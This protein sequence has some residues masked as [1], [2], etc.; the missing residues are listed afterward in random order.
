M[1]QMFTLRDL[2]L[3]RALAAAVC[4]FLLPTT[5]LA[6]PGA[7]AANDPSVRIRIPTVTVTAQK[8]GDDKQK[9]PVSVTAVTQSTIVDAGIQIISDAA[10]FAPNTIFTESTVRKLTNPRFRGIGSSP[11]NPGI[12]TYIDGVPHLNANSSNIEL[13]DVAQM[14]FV[15]GPQSALFGR[16]TIGGVISVQSARPSLGGWTGSFSLPVG[17]HG[18][19]ALRGGISGPVVDDKMSVGVSFAQVSRDGFT[20]NDLTGRPIDD[21]S[22]FS[23]KA[24]VLFV[25]N[26]DWEARVIVSGERARDGDYGLHDVATLRANPFHAA[27]DFTG[28]ADRDVLATTILARRLSGPFTISSATGFLSWQ[29]QDVTDLDY[30]PQP[31]IT[32]D[33][34]EEAFQ[35]T[36][37]LH[38]AST[39][40]ATLAF[41]DGQLRWQGGLSL[42]TQGYEQDAINSYAP[43]L[44][45]PFAVA[46]HT[47]QSALDDFGFG[48]FGQ[49][50]VTF[51]ELLDVS[52][53]ARIDYERKSATIRTFYEPV[54]AP[55]TFLED[56]ATFSNFSPQVSAAYRWAADRTVYGTLSRGFKAGGFNPAS[57]AGFETY[58][59]ERT[60]LLEGGAKTLWADGRV[61]ANAAVFYIDWADLQLNVPDPTV[62]AQFYITNVGS[63]TSRGIEFE[64]QARP[65][66]GLDIYSTLGLT[67]ARFSSGSRSSGVDVADNKI[68]YTPDYTM[69]LGAQWSRTYNE[70]AV[71]GRADVVFYGAFEY[72]D[73]NS[74]GQEGYS[75]VNL[76]ATV[77][78]G[79][80]TGELFIRNAFDTRYVPIAF[81]FPNFAP[82]GFIG[83]LGAPRTAGVSI[84]IRF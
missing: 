41:R 10:F 25:P 47:P 15:R 26:P 78:R 7:A 62:P 56:E 84:G 38:V 19:W 30:T 29:T 73:T 44:F 9:V 77:S 18:A 63:A 71:V 75:L 64:L 82:S 16:N 37:E 23:T 42:F 80:L 22:A 66:A 36:Q 53:G 32:R 46:Q 61:S 68:P 54:V 83:E 3:C 17:N 31:F 35:F 43:F 13:L 24:Q 57:P 11:S 59:E 5:G 6:Q 51:D 49:G 45:A 76:R 55:G 39:T 14:E 28:R 12:T 8:T 67:N 48:V 33:N 1:A 34:S 72:D 21:R 58:G 52:A 40:P 60:W 70:M 79:L 4:V 69:S 20:V 2:T 74:L 81:P 50:T 65:I 27:R